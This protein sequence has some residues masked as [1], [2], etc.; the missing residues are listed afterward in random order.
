[1]QTQQSFG[2]KPPKI[3]QG[4][5]PIEHGVRNDETTDDKKHID[6]HLSLITIIPYRIV[7]SKEITR[8]IA[9]PD[10]VIET[11]HDSGQCAQCA[12]DMNFPTCGIGG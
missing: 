6:S 10:K 1:M 11:H 7:F 5:F 9:V 8:R 4:I 12:N 2:E 3:L